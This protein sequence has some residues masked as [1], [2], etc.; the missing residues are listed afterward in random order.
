MLAQAN[1]ISSNSKIFEMF[2]ASILA[3]ETMTSLINS[4]SSTLFLISVFLQVGMCSLLIG[5][6]TVRGI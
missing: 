5:I 4:L 2:D 1:M 6:V 3:N